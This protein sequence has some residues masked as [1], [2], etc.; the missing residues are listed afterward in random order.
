MEEIKSKKFKIVF[1]PLDTYHSI[2]EEFVGKT[3]EI[4]QVY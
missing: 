4:V 3:R 2:P 1:W